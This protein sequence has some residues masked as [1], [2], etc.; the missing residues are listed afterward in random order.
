MSL[1]NKDYKNKDFKKDVSFSLDTISKKGQKLLAALYLVTNHLSDTDPLKLKIRT[2]A[3]LLPLVPHDSDSTNS[4][5]RSEYETLLSAINT[6]TA[7]IQAAGMAQIV[8][9]KNTRI[10]EAELH[11]FLKAIEERSGNTSNLSKTSELSTDFF[12]VAIEPVIKDIPKIS[13]G[14]IEKSFVLN[15]KDNSYNENLSQKSDRGA[16]IVSFI[17]SKTIASIKDISALFPV[18]S[19]KTIQRELNRLLAEGKI[20]KRGNKRWSMYLALGV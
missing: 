7:L 2:G 9:D 13:K 5:I 18:V 10:L 8:S 15:R 11:Y 6:I 4:I 17:N 19:E 12:N 1:I 20:K 3:V 14:H 16:E